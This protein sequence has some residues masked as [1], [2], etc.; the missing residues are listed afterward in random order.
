MFSKE[1]ILEILNKED[2]FIDNFIL[3]AF[4]KN[5]KIE[6]IYE[7][8]DGIEYFDEMA[9][10]KIRNG[11]NQKSQPK[12]EINIMD[13]DEIKPVDMAVEISENIVSEKP[14]EEHE[15][16]IIE[17][18]EN[19][20]IQ[21]TEHNIQP[22]SEATIESHELPVAIQKEV[23]AEL[24]NV[25]LDISNQTLAVLAE[26]IA[27]KITYDVADF[28]KKTDFIEDAVQ[29]GEYKKDNQILI[30][31]IDELISDNKILIKRIEELEKENNSYSK[32]FGNIYIKN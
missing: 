2:L 24:K 29:L 26:S 23:E 16:T 5:W 28:I 21:H 12:Y 3:E 14:A 4:I 15:E 1:K 31:K 11:I 27:R 8:A 17:P 10:E 18:S 30:E 6:P 25:T 13:K 7:D 22:L 19:E 9:L 20:E 32:V